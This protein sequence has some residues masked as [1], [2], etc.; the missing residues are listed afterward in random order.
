MITCADVQAGRG[1]HCLHVLGD[2]FSYAWPIYI[3]ILAAVIRLSVFWGEID[4]KI[5]LHLFEAVIGNSSVTEYKPLWKVWKIGTMSPDKRDTLT[6]V[7]LNTLRCHAR[8]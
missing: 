7:M 3:L 8:F 2:I 5:I 1:L 6:F 4:K